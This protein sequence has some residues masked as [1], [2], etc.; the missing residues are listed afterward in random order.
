[1]AA[2]PRPSRTASPPDSC[3][4]G[5]K[6]PNTEFSVFGI[7]LLVCCISFVYLDPSGLRVE[8]A[9]ISLHPAGHAQ[10]RARPQSATGD[11]LRPTLVL[12]A[13]QRERRSAA[14]QRH[15]KVGK[16]AVHVLAVFVGTSPSQFQIVSI[17]ISHSVGLQQHFLMSSAY[18]L[19]KRC[20]GRSAYRA[21]TA[22]LL[23]EFTNFFS[24]GLDMVEW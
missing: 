13:A 2:L 11:R 22:V 15:I 24:I 23:F 18:V 16:S 7:V 12:L 6:Y 19:Q 20:F 10:L 3:P 9:K 1:M 17:L 21:E 8:G 14:W 4:K 5:P